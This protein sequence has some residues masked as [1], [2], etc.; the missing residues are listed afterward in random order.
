MSV[1]IGAATATLGM[2]SV[3]ALMKAADE[4]LY[5]AKSRGR[6]RFAVAKRETAVTRMA[7]E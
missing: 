6:N 1:S 7:A 3:A 4:A 2:S 5:E